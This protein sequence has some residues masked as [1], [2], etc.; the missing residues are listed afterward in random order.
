MEQAIEELERLKA[1]FICFREQAA[2]SEE[3]HRGLDPKKEG[4]MKGYK[5]AFGQASGLV[6]QVIE[7]L[8]KASTI[9]KRHRT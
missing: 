3:H 6:H 2:I 4:E 8:K 5:I 7:S 9:N 1:L